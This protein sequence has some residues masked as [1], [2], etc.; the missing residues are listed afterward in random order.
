VEY[1]TYDDSRNRSIV[2]NSKMHCG[3]ATTIFD[4]CRSNPPLNKGKSMFYERCAELL[5]TEY[6]CVSF[7]Y[8]YRTRWN[9]RSAGHG[10]F[11]GFGIIRKFGDKIQVALTHPVSCHRIYDSEDEVYEFLKSLSL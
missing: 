11:P 6:N 8:A 10:R 3:W 9:N 2:L 5:G 1:W 4:S 7:P